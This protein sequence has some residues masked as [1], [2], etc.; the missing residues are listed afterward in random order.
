MNQ[1]TTVGQGTVRARRILVTG[2]D[3]F[4]G[5]GVVAALA[6]R[7]GTE[8]VLAL[9]VREVPAER[10]LNS[11]MYRMQDV[12]DAALVETLREHAIDTVVHLASIVTPGRGSSRAF[13]YDVDVNGTRNVLQ[14]CVA[15]GVQ[16][17]VVSSS[18]AAY[19]YWADNPDWIVETDALRG[20]EVF[21]YSHHKRLVEVMLAEYRQAHPELAQTV[22]RIGTILGER[23]DNQITAL[24]E[25]PRLLAIQGSDSPFVFIWDED[26]TGAILRALDG[27]APGCYNLAGD[28]ALSIHEIARRLGKRTRVLP[29]GLLRTALAV[30]SKL[31]LT[32]YGPEQLDFLRYRPV[33]LNKALKEKLGYVPAK[34]SAQALDALIA[35][36]ARQG[37]PLAVSDVGTGR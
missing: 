36:R 16:H 34:T 13:E 14:A 28:G 22:L 20:N 9:D 3:G 15:A 2:A 6:R 23:V 33:L 11:V 17:I 26:V 30:G 18:G 24:F 10:R 37:R 31:G 29:A 5:R 27:V 21:A 7:E 32:R 4:L 25:K 1:N 19:G 8:A 12:R 35:A